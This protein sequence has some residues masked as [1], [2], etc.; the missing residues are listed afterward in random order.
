MVL[1]NAITFEEW[2]AAALRLDDVLPDHY[3]WKYNLSSNLYS[4][5]HIRE[6]LRAMHQADQDGDVNTMDRL[7]RSGL[8]RNYG[9]IMNPSLSLHQIA[10]VSL[11]TLGL[12]A[13]GAPLTAIST[14][15]APA[16]TPAKAMQQ[17]AD[18]PDLVITS[19]GVLESENQVGN[20]AHLIARV[21][22]IGAKA[23]A[24]D[25]A[26]GVAFYVDGEFVAWADTYRQELKPGQFAIVR[27][28]GG[29]NGAATWKITPGKHL[30][31]AVADD[32]TRIPESNEEN[33]AFETTIEW[34]APMAM[35]SDDRSEFRE[36]SRKVYEQLR[37]LQKA[38]LFEV[39]NQGIRKE[40]LGT[41][42]D[43]NK[44]VLDL[45]RYEG[46]V[47]LARLQDTFPSLASDSK[48]QRLRTINAATAD[49]G[50]K[51][52]ETEVEVLDGK[53]LGLRAEFKDELAR[54]SMLN[55]GIE[56]R[57]TSA[58]QRVSAPRN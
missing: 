38:G 16:D 1:E 55:A 17:N 46:A 19:V 15:A 37:D 35:K 47:A 6:R 40:H 54:L 58:P 10:R 3:A 24:R 52:S 28:N 23:T 27:S 44:L 5:K 45:T 41:L 21:E 26:H 9:G 53:I 7:L 13:L 30:L 18:L 50:R 2:Q 32:V 43:L 34:K 29:P 49:A 11:G 57:K 56:M 8:E 48:A 22:N 42:D 39:S 51:L 25:V 12:C 20:Q 4:Y 36:V 14:L 31:R 33:N